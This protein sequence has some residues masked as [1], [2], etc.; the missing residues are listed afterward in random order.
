M[1]IAHMYIL[2]DL[3]SHAHVTQM[4]AH[5][6]LRNDYTHIYT[7]I[8]I[9][10]YIYIYKFSYTYARRHIHAR[11][12]NTIVRMRATRYVYIY[13][14]MHTHTSIH[15]NT[16]THTCAHYAS[17]YTHLKAPPAPKKRDT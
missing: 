17:T 8:Y 12:R 15:T 7:R 5:E 4:S 11:D 10:I 3:K 13:R 2:A 6:C 1:H 9:Y 16:Q 14:Y